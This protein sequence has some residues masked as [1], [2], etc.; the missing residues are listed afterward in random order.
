M[1]YAWGRAG[2]KRACQ[3]T[4]LGPETNLRPGS[5]PAPDVAERVVGLPPRHRAHLEAYAR[6]TR[7]ADLERTLLDAPTNTGASVKKRILYDRDSGACLPL[8]YP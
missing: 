5:L 7:P 8:L 1:G 2:A 4:N 6:S 3:E